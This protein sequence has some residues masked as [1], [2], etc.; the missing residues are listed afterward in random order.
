MPSERNTSPTVVAQITIRTRIHFIAGSPSI[1]DVAA[2][3]RPTRV[4]PAVISTMPAQRV[5]RDGFAQK[6]SAR[7][8]R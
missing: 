7:R 8:K 3:V 2:A 5:E 6:D 4:T 1:L